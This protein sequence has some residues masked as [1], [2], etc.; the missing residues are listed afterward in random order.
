MNKRVNRNEE[1]RR[2]GKREPVRSSNV[3]NEMP[4]CLTTDIFIPKKIPE[5]N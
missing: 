1:V 4:V 5:E 3:V 2:G